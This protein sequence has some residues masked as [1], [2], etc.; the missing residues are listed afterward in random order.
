MKNQ[1]EK[2][3]YGTGKVIFLS[4]ICVLL[5]CLLAAGILG[6]LTARQVVYTQDV[7]AAASA[8]PLQEI[9]LPDGESL[10]HAICTNYIKDA[11]FTDE[12]MANIL[13]DGSFNVWVGEK[14]AQYVQYLS[15]ETGIVPQITPEEVKA[16]IAAN[17]TTVQLH[18][19]VH[20]FS[21][22]DPRLIE[23]IKPDIAA[24]NASA[25]DFLERSFSGKLL[26][27]ALSGWFWIVL[28]VLAGG[29]L[30]WLIVI[31]IKGKRH[32]GTALKTFAVPALIP[33]LLVFLAGA[34]GEWG[35][36]LAGL[37]SFG[38]AWNLLHTAPMTVGGI[39]V[40]GCI[41]LFGLGI[42]WNTIAHKPADYGETAPAYDPHD[43]SA[44]NAP[45]PERVEKTMTVEPSIAPEVP[46]T[47]DASEP[48]V[49]RKY[50]RFCGGELVNQDAM[51]CYKCGKEQE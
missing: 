44:A 28:S 10:P 18:T 15:G 21:E 26:R 20:A 38:K 50:C 48:Q 23:R 19:G 43:L 37:G 33:S 13:R 4:F 24:W 39:A 2:Q 30:I 29:I 41:A 45:A 25:G 31:H 5:T 7:P 17:D 16:L 40:L 47:P 34:C 46:E 42:L 8:L 1:T 12:K 27:A 22:A 32:I 3:P 49:I 6:C 35:L 9:V 11:A 14:A 36:G 51:F